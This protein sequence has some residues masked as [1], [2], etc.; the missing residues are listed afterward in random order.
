MTAI[1]RAL[2][3]AKSYLDRTVALNE[4]YRTRQIHVHVPEK[5][6]D[7]TLQLDEA[8][9]ATLPESTARLRGA[10]DSLFFSLPV[11]FDPSESVGPYLATVDRD[12]LGR[13]YRFLDLGAQIA[14][15]AFG[16]NDP[17]VVAGVLKELPFVVSRYAH[18]EYQTDLSL[19]LKARLG[20]IAPV[21]TPRHFVVNTGAEGVENALKAVLLS[22]VRRQS[23]A[24][25][26]FFVISFEGAFH[27]RTLGCLAVTHRKK[28]RIG[29]PTFD[30]PHVLWPWE[31]PR[32]PKETVEREETTLRQI[33]DLAVTGRDPSLPRARATFQTVMGLIDAMLAA[34]RSEVVSRLA[35]ARDELARTSPDA[36]KRAQ[37][38]AAVLVEPIQGEGGVR[39]ASA[40]FFQRLRLLTSLYG[41][42]LVFDEVQTGFGMAGTLWAHEGFDLPL[43]P[44][45]VVWA[46]KAQNGVLFVSEELAAFF[47]EEKKFNTTW[48]GDSAG[49]ARLLA[50]IDRLDL[51]LVRRTGD[52]VREGLED[53]V[54]DHGK[55]LQDV[56]G[57]GCML[58]FDVVRPDWRDSLRERAF[59]RG[60]ILLPAGERTLRMY[61][62]FDMERYA[63]EEALGILRLA[64]R[65]ILEG[66]ASS[67]HA[68]GPERRIATFDVPPSRLELVELSASTFDALRSEVMAV[69]LDRY[70]SLAQSSEEAAREPRPS[71]LAYPESAIDAALASPRSIGIALRDSASGRLVAYALGAPL[72]WFD[73]AGVREDPAFGAGTAFYMQAIAVHPSVR[74]ETEI[75]SFVLDALRSRAATQGYQQLST[76]IEARAR[77]AGPAWLKAARE[78]KGIDD[79][80]RSGIRFVYV[81]A[82]LST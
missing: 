33:W 45:A 44:D 74:N 78:L 56:R 53:L 60:L 32:A 18:S 1:D 66:R 9:S 46:K 5:L 59:R 75:E 49:M 8:V 50:V 27:G 57:A 10:K 7:Q 43:P 55:L 58:A 71:L 51:G 80:L 77:D 23:D 38:V 12:P 61:P 29:F 19:R 81:E 6:A 16:E 36:V 41:V 76:L 68:G 48:E 13:P 15:Q 17:S 42:P 20:Q 40:R 67:P 64:V 72:E 82:P 70:G 2:Q 65:D 47:Q 69:E 73:E 37:R 22:R 24:A 25:A 11:A 54:R 39:T 34:D 21:G 14:T 52:L 30:W 26:G 63:V 28:A 79:Y 35:A 3:A 62:R 31:D 4:A